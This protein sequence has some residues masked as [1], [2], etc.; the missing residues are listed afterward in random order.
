[1]KVLVRATVQN[2]GERLGWLDTVKPDSQDVNNNSYP[3]ATLH[4]GSG[5]GGILRGLSR[6]QMQICDYLLMNNSVLNHSKND[7][8]NDN[9]R[10]IPKAKNPSK[11]E[12]D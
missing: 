9:K 12:Y 7:S 10:M 3:E 4:V 8:E 1:M 2:S 6:G 5:V 11:H